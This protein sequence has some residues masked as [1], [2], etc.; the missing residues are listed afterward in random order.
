[1]L[2]TAHFHKTN[3]TRFKRRLL[4]LGGSPWQNSKATSENDTVDFHYGPDL[5]TIRT[6]NIFISKLSLRQRPKTNVNNNYSLRLFLLK[7]QGKPGKRH[8]S[9]KTKMP[10][11]YFK[12][13]CSIRNFKFK[14]NYC[15]PATSA[16]P[17]KDFVSCPNSGAL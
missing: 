14:K 16:I 2:L 3:E 4:S 1:M 11:L 9:L 13:F 12:I 5:A 15:M 10:L 8:N 7:G 6:G 17:Y